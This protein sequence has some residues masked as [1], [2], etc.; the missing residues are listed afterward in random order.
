MAEKTR[1]MKIQITGKQ[2]FAKLFGELEVTDLEPWH[3]KFSSASSVTIECDEDVLELIA[4]ELELDSDGLLSAAHRYVSGVLRPKAKGMAGMQLGDLGEVLAYL[5]MRKAGE[6]PIRVV[7]YEL[8]DGQGNKGDFPRPDFLLEDGGGGLFAVEVKSTQAFVYHDLLEVN[9]WMFLQPCRGVEACRDEALR[10]LGYVDG[11]L[12]TPK[13]MLVTN[14]RRVVPF[15]ATEGRAIAIL[16]QDGRV[17]SLRSDPRY[18]TPPQCRDAKISRDCWDCVK[19][20]DQVV[21]VTLSNNPGQIPLAGGINGDSSNW[22]TAYRR[23]TQA[24]QMHEGTAVRQTSFKLVHETR[25]WLEARI[26]ARG[27][28][29]QNLTNSELQDFWASHIEAVVRD[30]SS[31]KYASQGLR[32]KASIAE[33]GSIEGDQVQLPRWQSKESTIDE[34]RE[35]LLRN[36][37]FPDLTPSGIWYCLTSND[38]ED[39]NDSADTAAISFDDDALVINFLSKDWWNGNSFEAA[40]QAKEIAR[41]LVALI[42]KIFDVEEILDK[43]SIEAKAITATV[44]EVQIPLGWKVGF[45]NKWRRYRHRVYFHSRFHPYF[46]LF[47]CIGDVTVKVFRDGRATFK[48]PFDSFLQNY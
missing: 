36:L 3:A 4:E 47:C 25:T 20:S 37:R 11:N 15:P 41:R 23:W 32:R 30:Y 21:A 48:M 35:V 5:L 7:S 24:L 12:A 46:S 38:Q 44:D 26:E 9:Q 14:K 13:H 28:E 2:H 1:R 16:M 17:S 29:A 42:S 10:Q 6:I 18:K 34:V 45:T 31:I 40:E 39:S 27:D 19:S 43:A 33:E 22:I 8:A